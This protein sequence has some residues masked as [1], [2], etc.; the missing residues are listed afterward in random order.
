MAVRE[1]TVEDVDR[2][3]SL[4]ETSSAT[5]AAL[6]QERTVRVLTESEE[7][8]ESSAIQAAVAFDATESAVHVTRLVGDPDGFTRLLAEPLT[9]A[10][11]E[12]L[13]VES[14]VP[15][16]DESICRAMEATD[17]KTD[18]PGPWFDGNPTI[19]YRCEPED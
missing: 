17:F 10:A 2:L 15:E 4:F 14:V 11:A 16:S 8:A 7:M 13:P 9:F 3:A 5:A 1:A 12:G 19:R 6:I 18:G